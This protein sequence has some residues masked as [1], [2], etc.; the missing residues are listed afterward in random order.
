MSDTPNYFAERCKLYGFTP[1]N[2]TI[3]LRQFDVETKEEVLKPFQ[4]FS[5]HEKGIEIMPYT[6][7]RLAIKISKDGSRW[8][9]KNYSIIRLYPEIVKPD[10]SI[11]KYS[12]PKGQGTP[13]MIPPEIVELYEKKKTIKTLYLTEG[14]FKA[15]K[16]CLHNIPT[17]GMVSITCLTDK[18]TGKLHADIFKIIEVCKVERLVWLTDADCRSISKDIDDE[19]DLYK[20]VYSFY[21]SINR[22]QELLSK[23][24]Q[25]KLYFAHIRE[26]LTC[27]SKGLDDLLINNPDAIDDIKTDALSFDKITGNKYEGNYFVKMNITHGVASVRN[28][29]LLNDVTQ[30]Y[31]FHLERRPELKGK[32][33]RFNGTLYSYNNETGQCIIEIPKSAADYFRV[34]DSYYENLKIPN[35]YG[36][37]TTTYR[38]RLKGTITEDH[39]KGILNHIAKYKEFC[40]VPD[41]RNYQRIIHNCFNVYHPFLHV[42]EEGDCGLTIE[43][44]KH[45]FGTDE[46][47][48]DDGSKICR[49]ELGLDYLT[50]LY[51]KPQQI[52]PILCL[53]SKERQTGKTTFAKWLKML[54]TENMAIVG[55][56]DFENA[57]NAHWITK[58]L[59]CVD[60]TKIDKHHVVERIKSLSTSTHTM[61]NAKGKDQVEVETFLKFILLSNND[62]SFINI[63]KEEIRFWV[64]RVP[65]ITKKQMDLEVQ[66][67]DEIPAFLNFLNNRKMVTECQERHWFKTDYLRTDTLDEIKRNSAPSLWKLIKSRLQIMFEDFDVKE[68]SL[69]SNEIREYLLRGHRYEDN[70]IRQILNDNG[71]TL[72]KPMRGHIPKWY[73]SKPDETGGSEKKVILVAFNNRAYT[74]KREDFTD[75]QFSGGTQQDISFD[76]KLTPVEDLPF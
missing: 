22:F 50:L 23:Y 42:P 28:Y 1:E 12:M 63:D 16:A 39:G 8:K 18:V 60:E 17:I 49:Y 31:L 41:H 13:P 43:F 58:L 5:E 74:F 11:Q 24:D 69:P 72:S 14:Y 35:R 57:F 38:G 33:F 19:K 46:L 53:V 52:L 47:L 34:G 37:L 61:L 64:L 21:S 66:M 9:N 73:E 2:N 68:I 6:L 40:N 45:I 29:F 67:M 55:N 62:N 71:Y 3:N 26:D 51:K 15:R 54:F 20:R 59:V 44:I 25:V 7:D 36:E 10:G 75:T 4:I 76:N 48:L 30:F 65:T 70:Y 27:A 32:K 56:Q